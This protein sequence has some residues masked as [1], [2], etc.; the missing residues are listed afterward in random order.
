MSGGARAPRGLACRNNHLQSARLIAVLG[1]SCTTLRLL[2]SLAADSTTRQGQAT[3]GNILTDSGPSYDFRRLATVS[4][5]HQSPQS[6]TEVNRFVEP[7]DRRIFEIYAPSWRSVQMSK[8]GDL[9]SRG[10]RLRGS[11]LATR[12]QSIKPSGSAA[13][14]SAEGSSAVAPTV[15]ETRRVVSDQQIPRFPHGNNTKFTQ[16]R[17]DVILEAL[18]VGNYRT[19]ACNLADISI[20]T[21][22]KWMNRGEAEG[23]GPYYEFLMAVLRVEAESENA[24]VGHVRHAVPND[25][26][27]GIELLQRRHPD[28]WSKRTQNE[29]SGPNGGPVELRVVYEDEVD[30]IDVDP[31]DIV[32]ADVV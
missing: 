17:V 22:W 1:A 28:R 3:S 30:T 9:K 12:P 2:C 5:L 19:V 20:Q 31:D 14:T 21:F 29:V 24:I 10:K 4:D 23:E 32:D 26:R 7:V 27:A 25:W 11:E 8:I 18:R 13:K 16:E 15:F 6:S